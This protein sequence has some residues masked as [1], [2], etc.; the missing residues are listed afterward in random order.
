MHALEFLSTRF[1]NPNPDEIIRQE[2]L[3]KGRLTSLYNDLSEFFKEAYKDGV[4]EKTMSSQMKNYG[5][6]AAIS[7]IAKIQ[8]HAEEKNNKDLV[9]KSKTIREKNRFGSE[10]PECKR[11]IPALVQTSGCGSTYF[12]GSSE[13]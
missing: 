9:E 1:Q 4:L 11:D 6:P 5:L 3:Y 10:A 13:G 7:E 12:P 8:M 2:H